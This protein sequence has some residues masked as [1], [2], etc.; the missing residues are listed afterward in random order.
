VDN[1][2]FFPVPRGSGTRIN[3]A[4]GQISALYFT[5]HSSY[6]ALQVMLT[7]HLVKSLTGNVSYTWGKSMDDGSSSTFGDT[8]ANSI[9]SL[10][11]WAPP[12]RRGLSD[13][14]IG[15]NFVANAVYNLPSFHGS[16]AWPING[17]QVGAI[18]QVS[19]GLPF[20]PLISGDPWLK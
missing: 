9:S 8:F 12:R 10:P 17:W 15:Q 13:F 6:N 1:N 2:Y 5:G 14:N 20:S 11:L 3:P 18:A 16:A 19:T 7:K 4:V